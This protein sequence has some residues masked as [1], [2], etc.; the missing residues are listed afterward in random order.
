[1]LSENTCNNCEWFVEETEELGDYQHSE[2]VKLGEGFCLIQDLF[3]VVTPCTP[4][5]DYFRKHKDKE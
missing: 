4:A 3:T 2:A 1:M 5:C